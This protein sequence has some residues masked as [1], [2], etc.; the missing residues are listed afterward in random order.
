MLELDPEFH[1]ALNYLGYTYGR[2][3]REPG[4]GAGSG[5]AGRW[6]STRT[7]APTSILWAGPTTGSAGRSSPRGSSNGP[8]AWSPRT[9]RCKSI[10][11]MSMLRWGRRRG[12]G[13]PTE[14]ALELG[15]RRHGESPAQAGRSRRQGPL[16]PASSGAAARSFYSSSPW[17]PGARAGRPPVPCPPRPW[18][19][20]R[21]RREPTARSG[22]TGSATRARKAKARS[23][24]PSAWRR[25][26]ATRS[27][28]WTRW[29]VPCG[30]WTSPTTRVSG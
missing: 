12:R 10:W 26:P 18:S 6:R 21:S 14:R 7:T 13:R 5:D 25:P 3:G 9:R 24:S 29:A 2:G 15:G 30:A 11:G 1:A 19:P 4:G 17:P 22:S 28:P 8:S 16:E 23:R 20:G 27:R